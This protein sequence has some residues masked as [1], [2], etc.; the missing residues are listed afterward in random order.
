MGN[1]IA[2]KYILLITV[3]IFS[4]YRSF[5][6]TAI[7][8]DTLVQASSHVTSFDVEKETQKYIDTLTPEQKAK[9]DAYFEGGYW[10]LLWS[11]LYGIAVAWVFLSKGLSSK[12]KG[13]ASKVKSKFK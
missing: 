6:I 5:G 9:S 1:P 2:M 11:L 10:L 12:I 13:I 3:I 7:Q 8:S 4:G